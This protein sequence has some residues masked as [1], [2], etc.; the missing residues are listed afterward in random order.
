M[1]KFATNLGYIA[2]VCAVLVGTSLFAQSAAPATPAA[3]AASAPS[4]SSRLS[5]GS[6]EAIDTATMAIQLKVQNKVETITYDSTTVFMDHGNKIEASS[7]A[8]GDTLKVEWIQRDNKKVAVRVD[9]VEKA[10][11]A[12]N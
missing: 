6:L 11:P 12:S 4:T 7:F 8:K 1:K 9:V 5:S 2:A 10:P 3:P